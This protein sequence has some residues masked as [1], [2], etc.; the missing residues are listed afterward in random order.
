[1]NKKPQI[2]RMC[3]VTR[4]LLLK[5]DLFRVVKNGSGVY[6]DKNQNMPGRGCYIKKDINI[7]E[8]ARK[9]HS[10]SKGLRREVDDYIYQELINALSQE[11]K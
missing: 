6:F 3:I 9:R 5:S 10:L 4:E 8:L 7:V 2:Y 1:M 11:R